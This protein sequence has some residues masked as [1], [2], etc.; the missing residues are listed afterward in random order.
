[1]LLTISTTH[2]PATDLGYLLHKNPARAQTFELAF[3]SAHVFYTEAT[4]E[5][6]T[7]ALLLDIDP[8]KLVRGPGAVLTDYVNDRPYVSSSFLSVAMARVFGTAMS[9]RAKERPELAGAPIPLEATLA[10]VPCRGAETLVED[11][12]GPLGYDVGTT[13]DPDDERPRYRNVR[14]RAT[15]T[16]AELLNHVYV[17]LP[18]ADNRKH[19]WIGEAEVEKLLAHGAGWLEEHPQKDFIVRRY[20]GHRHTLAADAAARL[21]VPDDAEDGDADAETEPPERVSLHQARHEWVIET[22]RKAG[23]RRIL[24]IGCNQ[25]RL[26]RLLADVPEFTEITGTDASVHALEIADRR[27]KLKRRRKSG[28]GR[29][30]LIQSAL[31]Y[32]DERLAGYDAAA[33]VEV[34]EHIDP[35]RLDAFER[36]LFGHARPALIAL[37]TPNREHNVRFEFLE[38]GKLRHRDHR[39]E[40]TREEFG[41]WARATAERYGY[42]VEIGEIG[43]ED[44][45]VGA[46]TQ[47]ALFHRCD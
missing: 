6:C 32:R 45:E 24:D 30:R 39:F 27:L 4:P 37:T 21:R 22:F 7:A 35:E 15:K 47:R 20:L 33:V 42:R 14:L 12:F 25:A 26:L 11:L 5:R 17:L 28:D 36:A 44:A 9:G 46:P 23:A 31:T 13:A 18:V 41:S 16:L 34:V 10:A 3:G 40:W 19:Y 1:M 43:P 29:I 8:L 2:R 38:P